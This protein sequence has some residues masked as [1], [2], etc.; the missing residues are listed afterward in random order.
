MRVELSIDANYLVGPLLALSLALVGCP[1]DIGW[2]MP[3]DVEHDAEVGSDPDVLFPIDTHQR[4]AGDDAGGTD[5]SNTIDYDQDQDDSA[6]DS[7]S[8]LVVDLASDSGPDA[9]DPPD[10]ADPPDTSDDLTQVDLR[11]DAAEACVEV[12]PA[13][14]GMREVID[15]C[16]AGDDFSY[17]T[18]D[19]CSLEPGE[20]TDVVFELTLDRSRSL[21]ID[22]L[23]WDESVHVDTNVYV[24]SSCEE[25]ESQMACSD[26]AACGIV[27]GLGRCI[28]RRQP[29]FSTL[30]GTLD[31][32]TYFLVVDSRDGER[33][34]TTFECGQVLIEIWNY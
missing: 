1:D 29:R 13:W 21:A 18:T 6:S 17:E 7:T 23:D 16:G 26:D 11:P 12:R 14:V 3:P 22:V 2:S 19:R 9:V 4:D 34:G 31:A 8:D 27:R 20:G 28:D 30:M 25:P 33:D 5:R 32:G 15:L 24:R 10:A